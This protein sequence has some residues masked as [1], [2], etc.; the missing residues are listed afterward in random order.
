M[1]RVFE[2]TAGPGQELPEKR[3]PRE[4]QGLL[5][6]EAELR[7]YPEQPVEEI[8]NQQY[9]SG[10]PFRRAAV[11]ASVFRDAILPGLQYRKSIFI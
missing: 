7:P 10:N 6:L 9:R 5:R 1:G 11:S 3:G 4:K 8:R 2:Q